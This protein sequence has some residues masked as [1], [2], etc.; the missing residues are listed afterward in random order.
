MTSVSFD[1]VSD[2]YDA[3][4]GLPPDVAEQ[5]T[6][7]ILGLVATIDDPQFLEIGVGT[8]RIALPIVQQGYA[9]TGIDISEKMMDEF[10]RKLPEMPTRLTLMAADATALPFCDR[11][12]DVVLAVHVLHLIPDWQQ[13]LSE[14]RRVLKPSGL[15]LYTHGRT[16]ISPA[17]VAP[18]GVIPEIHQQ[19]HRILASYNFQLREYGAT[20]KQ[21]LQVL[22]TQGAHLETL[23]VVQWPIEQS[24]QQILDRYGSR[25]YSSSWQIPEPIFQAAIA[26]L[27]AWCEQQYESLEI[28]CRRES[29][30]ALTVVRHW[31]QAE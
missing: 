9:Y 18:E 8:G 5:I 16:G 6:Q 4:R 23:T 15:F 11:S 20:A 12:F 7:C 25:S 2:V 30:F 10:R 3:T 17:Q 26:D 29:Q 31:H 19:W 1:R 28:R 14:L 22:Q 13:A 27:T 21:V 24:V